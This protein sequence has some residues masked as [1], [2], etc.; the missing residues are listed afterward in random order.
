MNVIKKKKK[1][2]T[3]KLQLQLIP[4]VDPH[5]LTVRAQGCISALL[6]G[7]FKYG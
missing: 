1:K 3:L 2:A 5:L 6:R 7:K 4:Y